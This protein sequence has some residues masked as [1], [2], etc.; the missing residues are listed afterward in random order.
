MKRCTWAGYLPICEHDLC[1]PLLY[2]FYPLV[3][4]QFPPLVLVAV[5]RL[6]LFYQRR[7]FFRHG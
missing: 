1:T 2:N 4:T 3:L 7:I 5:G 6:P